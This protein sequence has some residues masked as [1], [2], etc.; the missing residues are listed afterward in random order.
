MKVLFFYFWIFSDWSWFLIEIISPSN[1]IAISLLSWVF[2]ILNKS[3]IFLRQS[4]Y[5][6]NF[7]EYLPLTRQ[8]VSVFYVTK[9]TNSLISPY[10]QRKISIPS[11]IYACEMWL[12]LSWLYFLKK[13][14]I[15]SRTFLIDCWEVV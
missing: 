7:K 2:S 14:H 12:M 15:Y 9:R 6:D 8:I 10:L 1:F 3:S 5:W 4:Q 13:E 11:A